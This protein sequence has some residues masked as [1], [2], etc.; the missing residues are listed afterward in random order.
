MIIPMCR[1]AFDIL[2]YLQSRFEC[3]RCGACCEIEGR[4]PVSPADVARIT[5]WLDRPDTALESIPAHKLNSI[6]DYYCIRCAGDHKLYMYHNHECQLYD[7]RPDYCRGFPFLS[8]ASGFETLD[9]LINCPG[10]RI[11]LEDL[12]G[13]PAFPLTPLNA[14]VAIKAGDTGE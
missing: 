11:V 9:Y 14:E 6:V 8:L 2:E 5:K 10:A 7:A 3:Q 12:F 4:T 1:T 13:I